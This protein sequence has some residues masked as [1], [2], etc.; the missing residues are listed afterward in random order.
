MSL[1]FA[2]RRRLASILPIFTGSARHISSTSHLT[3]AESCL[4]WE[5]MISKSHLLPKP[6]LQK[7]PPLHFLQLQIYRPESS[8]WFALESNHHRYCWSRN[9]IL[10]V[11]SWNMD[12]S[13][14]SPQDRASAALGH[15]EEHF[16]TGPGNLIVMLEEVRHE[17]LKAILENAWVQRNFVLTNA[18][19]PN[20][21]YRDS[22]RI[23]RYKSS[24][25]E[26]STVF[27]SHDGIKV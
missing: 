8:G 24:R 2:H 3:L 9:S 16:G 12:W 6:I 14:P 13:S 15:L 7:L 1:P 11:V 17:S 26:S 4:F 5:H 25:L 21:L 22:R 19:S 27:Y 18:V 10:K 20:S 23:I